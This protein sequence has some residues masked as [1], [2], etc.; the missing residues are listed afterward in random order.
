[1]RQ[2][3]PDRKEKLLIVGGQMY[4]KQVEFEIA[5]CSEFSKDIHFIE[6]APLE[7]MN[8]LYSGADLFAFPSLSEGFGLPVL[9]AMASGTPVVTSSVTSMPEIGGEAVVTVDPL[10]VEGLAR[11]MD[12]VLSDGLLQEKMIQSGL[13][14]A[15]DFTWEKMTEETEKLYATILKQ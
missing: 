5:K 4:E 13:L 2:I 6:F 1:M 7:D 12:R 9:E 15:K 11:E 14:R 10:D 3:H 8:A